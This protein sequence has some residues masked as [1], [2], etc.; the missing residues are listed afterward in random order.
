M[1]ATSTLASPE[2]ATRAGL[3]RGEQLTNGCVAFRGVPFAKPPVGALRFAAPQPVPAWAGARD[4]VRFG[5]AVPQ[6][7]GARRG[8]A[9]PAD[10]EAS[11]DYL[12]LN[13]WTPA[14]SAARPVMV[15]IHGGA[16]RGGGTAT[17]SFEGSRLALHGDVVVVTVNHRVGMEG[18]AQIHGAP[19]NRGL[20]DVVAALRWV[21]ENIVGFGG[22]P[23]NVTVFGQS[24]GAGAVACLLAMP[25][26]RGLFHRAIAQSVPGTFLTPALSSAITATVAADLGR[27]PT[28][29]EL[30]Q[31]DPV[32]LAEAADRVG[33]RMSAYAD[34]WGRIAHT[35]TPFSPVVDGTVLP[36]DPWTALSTGAAAPVPLIVGHT[37]D[38]FRAFSRADGRIPHIDRGQAQEAVTIFGPTDET[39]PYERL[40][41]GNGVPTDPTTLYETVN[42]DWLFRM[43][44]AHLAQANAETGAPTYLFERAYTVPRHDGIL[45]APHSADHPLVFGNLSGGIADRYYVQPVAAETDRLG[46]RMRRAWASFAHHGDPGWAAFTTDGLQTMIFDA[47]PTQARY[48]H[49]A[50]LRA[51]R[52]PDLLDLAGPA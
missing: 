43:P 15:W 33:D 28:A 23:G 5:P 14:L 10:A 48:P 45:G 9:V 29:Q 41:A 2:V 22:D 20:L 37:R 3:L 24:A 21:A 32:Q 51:F 35:S 4:A 26:A 7:A 44:S 6:S 12:T 18:Y 47:E 39:A 52:R 40:L 19:A 11:D 13:I 30:A 31:V 16:Y 27:A 8:S 49:E 50:S 36:T 34:H 38:E 17:P 25:T 46:R 1:T 42:S